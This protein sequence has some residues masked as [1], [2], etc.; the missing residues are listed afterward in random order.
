MC[1][2]PEVL[3]SDAC[4]VNITA[5]ADA[6]DLQFDAIQVV[7]HGHQAAEIVVLIPDDNLV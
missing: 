4:D 6:S 5:S 1:L 2:P 7:L 3:P